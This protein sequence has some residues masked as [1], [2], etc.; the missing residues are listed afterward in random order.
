MAILFTYLCTHSL[1]LLRTSYIFIFH[2]QTTNG[3]SNV[4]GPRLERFVLWRTLDD[5][6]LMEPYKDPDS[7]RHG[8][9]VSGM[10]STA[11]TPFPGVSHIPCAPKT[12]VDAETH[13]HFL[14]GCQE[15]LRQIKNANQIHWSESLFF[16]LSFSSSSG[17]CALSGSTETF[18]RCS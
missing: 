6:S 12:M 15:S 13:F 16:F 7:L 10:A 8:T 9:V 4:P 1:L 18:I 14:W 17:T 3:K 11:C 5:H 2:L